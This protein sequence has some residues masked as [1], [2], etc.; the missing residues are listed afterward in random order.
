MARCVVPN[1]Y[2]LSKLNEDEVNRKTVASLLT[3][4]SY[5]YRVRV[6]LFQYDSSYC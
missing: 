2:G 3:K 4:N 1:A 6:T 5:L